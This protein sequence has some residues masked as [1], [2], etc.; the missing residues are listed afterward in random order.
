V[1]LVVAGLAAVPLTVAFVVAVAPP[2]FGPNMGSRLATLRVAFGAGG[3]PQPA[4]AAK[5]KSK[6]ATAKSPR[7]NKPGTFISADG[8]ILL[9]ETCFMVV[10]FSLTILR[11]SENGLGGRKTSFRESHQLGV[12]YQTGSHY[13]SEYVTTQQKCGWTGG[14]KLQFSVSSFCPG[15]ATLTSGDLRFSA[16]LCVCVFELATTN[17]GSQKH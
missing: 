1:P 16:H 6:K 11:G 12:F 10:S 5:G 17:S 14:L 9:R 15:T 7:I 8:L 4:K 13:V 2:Q 3:A